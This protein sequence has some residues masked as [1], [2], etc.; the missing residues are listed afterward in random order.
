MEKPTKQRATQPGLR[1][2][3]FAGDFSKVPDDLD[4]R[5]PGATTTAPTIT[6]PANVGERVLLRHRGVIAV[7]KDGLYH[8]VLTSD[9]GSVLR[10]D[11]Q[12]VVDHDGLHGPT[13]KRGTIALMAGDH[14]FDLV[15]FNRTGGATLALQW[16]AHGAAPAAI[17]AAA[18]RH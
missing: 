18:L 12:T 9:D 1:V 4:A 10:L 11:G 5:Q 17:D 8:F 14:T 16:H 2:E 6:L 3:R 15:W 7:P 13:E